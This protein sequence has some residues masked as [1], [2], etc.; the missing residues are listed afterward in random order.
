[1][2]HVVGS[3]CCQRRIRQRIK[4]ASRA[5]GAALGHGPTLLSWPVCCSGTNVLCIVLRIVRIEVDG[6]V[7][8][9]CAPRSGKRWVQFLV[10]VCS[11]SL[12]NVLYANRSH[13]GGALLAAAAAGGHAALPLLRGRAGLGGGGGGGPGG[14]RLRQQPVLQHFVKAIGGELAVGAQHAQREAAIQAAQARLGG[15]GGR[16]W[17]ARV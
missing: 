12:L 13:L 16:G 17:K 1:M 8:G 14:R 5:G 3:E 9:G 15:M 7:A 11:A 6:R 4:A 2:R 10:L